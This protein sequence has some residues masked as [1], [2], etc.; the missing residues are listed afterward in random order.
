[1]KRIVFL[2]TVLLVFA[3]GAFAENVYDIRELAGNNRFIEVSLREMNFF[4]MPYAIK[5]IKSSKKAVIKYKQNDKQFFVTLT[6]NE[7]TELYIILRETADEDRVVSVILIPKN[8]PATAVEI[9]DPTKKNEK[10]SRAEK[11]LP[12][13]IAIRNIILT[14]KQN[15]ADSG[16]TKKSFENQYIITKTEQLLLRKQSELS[17]YLYKL[18]TWEV[19]NNTKEP[20]SIEE[21]DFYVHGMRAISLDD[22]QLMPESTT[23]LYIV[24]PVGG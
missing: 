13:E 17:G 11:S 3:Q 15:V 22:H 9:I 24:Y 23:H 1:M 14:G 19:T 2:I 18:E 6:N 8:I 16:Y 4:K 7:P 10:I 5:G 20:L 21:T 12:Y